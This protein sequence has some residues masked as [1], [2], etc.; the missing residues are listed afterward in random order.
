MKTKLIYLYGTAILVLMPFKIF[1]WTYTPPRCTDLAINFTA[2]NT[3]IDVSEVAYKGVVTTLSHTK[4]GVCNFTNGMGDDRPSKAGWGY[5][6]LWPKKEY[7]YDSHNII[8]VEGASQDRTLYVGQYY[9]NSYADSEKTQAS[10]FSKPE[11]NL[12]MNKM[13][14]PGKTII[15]LSDLFSAQAHTAGVGGFSHARKD[16]SVVVSYSTPT[17][18][19][20][21]RPSCS[22]KVND[23]AFGVQTVDSIKKGNAEK[24][25]LIEVSC[26]AILPAY[27]ITL[28][29]SKGINDVKKGII[30][31]AHNNIGYQLSWG[32]GDGSQVGALGTAVELGVPL[33]PDTKPIKNNFTIPLKV[34]P[35]VLK[36]TQGVTSGNADSDITITLEFK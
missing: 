10:I 33:S 14:P 5:L 6:L 25:A 29:S 1:A 3:E 26:E 34:K 2:K 27:S 21:Y 18:T 36:N 13:P 19:L 22:A 12:L 32:K 30:K 8:Y 15:P 7:G 23:I 24:E 4:S 35:M 11:Q 31:S 9:F 20:I 28:N 16:E 17:I